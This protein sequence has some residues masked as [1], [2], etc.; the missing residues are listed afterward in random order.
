MYLFSGTKFS[1]KKSHGNQFFFAVKVD[2]VFSHELAAANI[3]PGR[4]KI[5][6]AQWKKNS[7]YFSANYVPIQIGIF[8][9]GKTYSV[10]PP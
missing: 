4:K 3:L 9:L 2:S 6:A 5:A 10:A 1:V 7:D 8:Y